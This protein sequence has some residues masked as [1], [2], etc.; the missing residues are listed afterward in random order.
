V[1]V[2]ELK[3]EG[4]SRVTREGNRFKLEITGDLGPVFS[5]LSTMSI[6]NF[7][8][9]KMRLEEIFWEYFSKEDINGNGESQSPDTA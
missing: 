9:R 4:V 5:R 8:Y 7:D 2:E 6:E 3:I 1:T